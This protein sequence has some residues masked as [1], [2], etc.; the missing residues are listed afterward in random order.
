M[1]DADSKDPGLNYKD[2]F[3]SLSGLYLVLTPEFQI[4]DATDAYLKATKTRRQDVL[5][6]PLFEVFPDNPDDAAADGVSNLRRSLETVLKTKRLHT[7]ATQKYDIRRPDSEGGGFEVR[8]W[9]PA[10]SP[11]MGPDNE[12][13]YLI[14]R[15]RDVTKLVNL[16]RAEFESSKE[17]DRFFEVTLDMLCIA[18]S[19]GYFKRLSPAFTNTLGWSIQEML[20]TPFLNFIHP[21]DIEASKEAVRNQVEAGEAVLSFENRYRH[22]NG[23]WR[24]LSWKSV[25]QEGG[26]MYAAA[27]DVTEQ[28]QMERDLIKAKSEADNA[29][30]AKSEFLSRM[31]HELRTPLNSVLGFA[32][33]LELQHKDP[34]ILEGTTAIIRGGK[35]LLQ[36]IDEVL[37]IARI[38]TGRLAISV[39]PVPFDHVLHRTIGLLKPMSES[40]GI[41]IIVEGDLCPELHVMADRQRLVQVMLNLLSNAIKYNRINGKVTIRCLSEDEQHCRIEV[42]D[43]GTG[44]AEEQVPLIF[45]PFHRFG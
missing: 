13:Q 43:T 32:Q 11:I 1:A 30:R 26:F 37:D 39:E 20:A 38:E 40:A 22:K 44:I 34:S 5:G 21:D 24:V 14:H 36:L 27:R 7:M 15:V 42:E 3:Q 35:H 18:H 29:N 2:L 6:K 45:E 25:P 31:S 4:V 12:V 10:N 9:S 23:S 19:D 41:E 16:E 33:F 28:K 8:F 17:L